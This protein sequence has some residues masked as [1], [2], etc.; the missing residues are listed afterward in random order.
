LAGGGAIYTPVVMAAMVSSAA[1]SPVDSGRR[2]A[3][4]ALSALLLTGG[5]ASALPARAQAG[6]DL[7]AIE[8]AAADADLHSVLVWQAGR[9]LVEHYRRSKDKPVNDWFARE[10]TFGPDVMH[11]LRSISKSVVALLVGQ[12]VGRGQIDTATRVLDFYPMLAN[13][14]RDGRDAIRISHLLDMASGL[15]WNE[16]ASTYGSSANDETRLW[17]DGSPARY[18][19]DR[20]LVAEPGVL[21]NYN[22]GH[23]ALLAEILEQ[24]SGRTLLDLARTDLFEPLGI[25]HWEWRSGLHRRP[26]AYAGLRLTPPDLLRL[27]QLIL[28]GGAWQGRQVVPAAWVAATLQPSITIDKGPFRYGHHWWDGRVEREGRNLAWTAGIGNGGQRLFV[29]PELDLAVV[30][31]AGAYNSE[32]IGRTE[33]ALFRQIVA[34]A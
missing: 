25:T 24:R 3:L 12:A 1:R 17:W 6:L 5:L 22:G 29:V 8:R 4:G 28:A 9:I 33:F 13:L 30:F 14:R 18:V 23:T 21:W 32:Q 19:L 20:P 16:T 11:D 27:G 34:A 31:T 26:L 2:H 15:A 10:V 7:S